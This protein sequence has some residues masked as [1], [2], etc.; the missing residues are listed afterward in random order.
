MFFV[1]IYVGRFQ[2]NS[3]QDRMCELFIG[4]FDSNLKQE[5]FDSVPSGT[6]SS[7]IR[8]VRLGSVQEPENV[9]SSIIAENCCLL[10]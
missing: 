6:S 3:G 2:G 4:C 9:I 7:P 5:Y 10:V 1:L 8:K